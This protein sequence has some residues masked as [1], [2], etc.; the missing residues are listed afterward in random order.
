MKNNQMHQIFNEINNEIENMSRKDI[1]RMDQNIKKD[2]EQSQLNKFG[3]LYSNLKTKSQFN[4][5]DLFCKAINEIL[6][7]NNNLQISDFTIHKT[8]V[9]EDL[10]ENESIEILFTHNNN[11]QKYFVIKIKPHD[12]YLSKEKF[13]LKGTYTK[14]YLILNDLL[15]FSYNLNTELIYNKII[16]DLTQS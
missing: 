14:S 4:E 3:V 2:I 6:E 7:K 15:T 8:K 16:N 10:F 5:F 11:S 12:Y 9:N 1:D 13:D